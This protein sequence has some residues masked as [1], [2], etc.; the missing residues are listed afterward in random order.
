MRKIDPAEPYR[1]VCPYCDSCQVRGNT[2]T[3]NEKE[4]VKKYWCRLCDIQLYRVFDK[5]KGIMA[6][7]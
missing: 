5:K 4:V 3:G 7:P 1:Y 6:K 2:R